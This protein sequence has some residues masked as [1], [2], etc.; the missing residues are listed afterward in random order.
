MTER[1]GESQGE[2]Q[3]TKGLEWLI[4]IL[5][6]LQYGNM[7]NRT[8]P[9]PFHIKAEKVRIRVSVNAQSDM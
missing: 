8:F 7:K 6:R 2:I 3:V 9:F 1:C 4:A 5:K